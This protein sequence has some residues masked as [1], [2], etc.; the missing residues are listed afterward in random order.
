MRVLSNLLLVLSVW[1]AALLAGVAAAQE[2]TATLWAA[3]RGGGHVALVRHGATT[4]G[5]GDP[6]GFRLDDCATQRNL[7]DKG[8][9]EARRL[10]EQFRSEDVAVG[11]L[12]SSQWCRCQETAA[13]MDLGPVE[14]S[15]TFNNA[16]TLRDRVGELT[17]GARAIVAGWTEPGTL[18][19]VTHGANILPLT[20]I[21]PEEGG[22]V[23][24]KPDPGSAAKLRT[25]GHMSPLP[26][27]P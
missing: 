4:G 7:T 6:P 27:G 5:A 17:A 20:G 26:L 24:V 22:V 18:V 16:F 14:P 10:G 13:L 8:R 9:A 21:M 19:V 3:L 1:S 25:L 12:M 11:R 2:D 15:A 23:I